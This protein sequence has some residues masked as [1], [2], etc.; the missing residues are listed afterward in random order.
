MIYTT[1]VS[2]FTIPEGRATIVSS[3]FD[4][5]FITSKGNAPFMSNISPTVP[6]IKAYLKNPIRSLSAFHLALLQKGK[7][8][9]I[10]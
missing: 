7:Q 9:S 3:I 8:I 10:C 6:W 2:D 4:W 5:L 1:Y